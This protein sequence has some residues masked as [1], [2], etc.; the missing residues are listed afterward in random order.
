MPIYRTRPG[1]LAYGFRLGV[2]AIDC[3]QPFVPGD[4]GN[5]S[6]WPWPVLYHRIEGCSIQRLVLEGDR[7][8]EPTVVDAARAL[9]GEGVDAIISNCG[10][11]AR[12]Q[13]AVA[14]AVNVPV[15]LSALLQ[16]PPVLAFTGG[17]LVGVITASA[18]TLSREL[19]DAAGI[20]R[21]APVPVYGMEDYPAFAEPFLS[22][23]GWVDTDALA[24]A[25]DD[26]G[27]RMAA[28]H[29][30]LTALVLECAVLPPYAHVFEA[31]AG[32]PVYDAVTLGRFLVSGTGHAPPS[33][34]Y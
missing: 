17:G 6:T 32:V 16:V 27:R 18:A 14:R 23:C 24:A 29:P 3:E 8:L 30:D 10:F 4:A 12:F 1:A 13:N 7:T 25:A 20:P 5:A 26:L 11:L 9:E 15:G 31:A 21:D 19:L 28:A 2:L 22:D 34:T 33:G